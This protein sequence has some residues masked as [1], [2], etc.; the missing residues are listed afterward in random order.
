[1]HTLCCHRIYA[2]GVYS[3]MSALCMRIRRHCHG[4]RQC[5]YEERSDIQ[6]CITMSCLIDVVG[7]RK[8]HRSTLS[9]NTSQ[10]PF[11][12]KI[13]QCTEQQA[14]SGSEIPFTDLSLLCMATKHVPER[15][16][17]RWNLIHKLISDCTESKN[18]PEVTQPREEPTLVSLYSTTASKV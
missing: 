3:F 8:R 9:G 1:M 17:K 4:C 14:R 12:P 15:T 6:L 10:R 18:S 2:C 13:V 5:L 11:L 16:P 7:I